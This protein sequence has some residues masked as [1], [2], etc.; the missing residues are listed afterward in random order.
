MA[1]PPAF[2]SFEEQQIYPSHTSS[3]PSMFAAS[4]STMP[5]LMQPP[6]LS[7][8]P[9]LP[10]NQQ[11]NLPFFKLFVVSLP[12]DYTDKDLES[13]FSPFG[14][15]LETHILTDKETKKSKSTFL[16]LLNAITCF[17]FFNFHYLTHLRLW[18]CYLFYEERSRCFDPFT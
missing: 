14:D 10:M 1:Q 12:G 4:N 16:F 6:V 17:I 8:P 11:Q 15:V 7:R 18:F 13:L 5:A 9:A 2:I 3:G